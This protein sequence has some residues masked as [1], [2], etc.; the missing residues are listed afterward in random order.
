MDAIQLHDKYNED[1]IG[2]V[3]LKEGIEF[4]QITKAW[5]EYQKYTNSNTEEQPDI[6]DFVSSGNWD[7]CDVLNLEFYQP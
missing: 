5:D 7:L 3:I 1:V 6:Y 2:T 4:E